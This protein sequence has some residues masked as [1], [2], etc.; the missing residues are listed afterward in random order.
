MPRRARQRSCT[1]IYHVILRG[2]NRQQ[3]F[4][5]EED[6]EYFIRLLNRFQNVSQY[7]VYAYCLMGNHIHLLIK[8]TQE[9]LGKIFQRIGAAFVYWYNL[10]YQRVGHLFQDR[11][12]SEPVETEGYF[13]TVLRY[14]IWNP[15]KAG[16]CVSP[17][18]YPYSNAKAILS[19]RRPVFPCNLTTDELAEYIAQDKEDV[20]MDIFE[21]P[22]RGMTESAAKDLIRKEFGTTF[23]TISKENRETLNSSIIRLFKQ[24]ISIRQLSRLTGI[25]KSIIERAVR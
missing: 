23:P 19:Q 15:V 1:D 21:G 7:E 3:V 18:D 22:R 13:L 24:G 25:S 17:F 11:F 10:K 20:C 12:K 14:I 6:Y 4:Y 9:P 16:L 8:V 5:D 2:I